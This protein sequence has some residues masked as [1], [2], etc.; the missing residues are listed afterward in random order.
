MKKIM[1]LF[2]SIVLILIAGMF[3]T[4]GTSAMFSDTETVGVHDMQAGTLNLKVSDKNPSKYE[5]EDPCTVHITLSNVKPMGAFARLKKLYIRNAGTLPGVLSI[6]FTIIVNKEN[7][8]LEPEW[9]DAGDD[10]SSSEGEL[11][12]Y[13]KVRFEFGGNKF[14][15]GGED[16]PVL[17][18]LSG[19]TIT[20]P[21]NVLDPGEIKEFQIW[22]WLPANTGNIVQSDSVEFDIIFHLDQ[23]TP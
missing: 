7:N 5:M 1:P 3:A 14:G 18:D 8:C 11:G 20:P 12:D 13:L 22:Y 17:N 2:G 9:N 6:E 16:W 21:D 19:Q 15:F 4:L 10:S 23:V